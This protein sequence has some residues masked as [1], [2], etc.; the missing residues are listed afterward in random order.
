MFICIIAARW[1][2][3]SDNRP[4]LIVITV[5]TLRAD[6]LASY[7]HKTIKTPRID[8]LARDGVQFSN[9]LSHSPQT[10]P[11][12]TSIFTGTYPSFHQVQVN[13]RF[14][15]ND[16]ITTLAQVMKTEGYETAAFI[17][18]FVMDS[19]F[20]LNKGFD[21]YD[22]VFESSTKDKLFGYQQCKAEKVLDHV[23][24]W[25]ENQ[26]SGSKPFF[27]WVHLFDPHRDYEPPEPFKSEYAENPYDG[28]IAYVDSQLARLVDLLKKKKLYDNTLIL[29]TSDHG[30]SLGEHNELTHSIF[31]YRATQH[32]PLI[33]KMPNQAYAKTDVS[34]LVRHVDIVPTLLD[35]L[36]IEPDV[37]ADQLQGKSFM[38][39]I[40]G[41]EE[42]EARYSYA[43]SFYPYVTYG[44]CPPKAYEDSQYKYIDLPVPELYDLKSDP[45]ETKNIYSE[46]T[47]L[48]LKFKK[49]VAAISAK[50]SKT[51]AKKDKSAE[52]LE[53]LKTLGY[54]QGSS[55][56]RD[57]L[58]DLGT[59]TDPKHEAETE[60]III[61]MENLVQ[62]GLYDEAMKIVND[63]IAKNPNNTKARRDKAN[64]FLL[65][66]EFKKALSELIALKNIKKDYIDVH[67]QLANLYLHNE[68]DLAKAEEE[69]RNAF[70]I[71][72]TDPVVWMVKG[73]LESQKGNFVEALESYNKA[74]ELGEKSAEFYQSKG[75]LLLNL[76][77]LDDAE[78]YLLKAVKLKVDQA[79]AHFDLGVLY[80]LKGNYDEALKS[81]HLA[82]AFDDKKIKYY[83]S[84]ANFYMTRNNFVNAVE[85]LNKALEKDKTNPGIFYNIGTTY[86][87][88]GRSD[89]AIVYLEKAIGLDDSY[90]P[91]FSNLGIAYRN[92]GNHLKS[93]QAFKRSVEL[94]PD[95]SVYWLNLANAALDLNKTDEIPKFLQTSIDK[96]MNISQIQ[97]N[98]QLRRHLP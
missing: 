75:A 56:K 69:I 78:K 79:E 97:K 80:D 18:S 9:A 37:I 82:I 32:I 66:E 7:G 65:Q 3:F 27:S 49:R 60:V 45:R 38:K 76:Y 42:E 33:I 20:G 90:G 88:W 22:N 26:W 1:L 5:D 77:Q 46:Q 86:L 52:T 4:N 43:E 96:G 17:A 68:V 70:A 93:Y 13:G 30:E 89:Q 2:L 41:E 92:M 63:L 23:T 84:L 40:K 36:E 29:L 55:T 44:W 19:R 57:D 59:C 73:D 15:K 64:I 53:K 47:S 39:L 25:I 50:Q 94:M 81:F 98:E 91:A 8:S 67:L 14:F 34:D 11:S 21:H 31:I 28:E 51:A 58:A 48:A 6:H 35:I 83:S 85:T 54:V 16:T 72:Q 71:S 95:E 62:I 61:K 24:N 12:H 10:L 74:E 87:L